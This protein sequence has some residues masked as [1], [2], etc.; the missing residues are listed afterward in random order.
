MKRSK[1]FNKN[2]PA[3]YMLQSTDLRKPNMYATTCKPRLLFFQF[4]YDP[5]LPAFLS[6]HA[7]EHAKCLAHFFE[8]TV[9]DED[10]DYQEICELYAPDIAVFESGV[11]FASCR[12]PRITNTKSCPQVPKIGFLN[13]DAFGEG[14]SGFL[15]DM[16]HWGIETFFAIATTAAEHIPELAPNLFIWPNFVDADLYRDYGESK[17]IPVLFTGNKNALYPWRQ[18]IARIVPRHYP[19]LVCP[20]PGY[21]PLQGARQPITGEPYARML[22]AAW[23]IPACGTVAREVVRKHFEVPACRSCLVTQR[24]FALE[25]AGFV[26]MENCVFA[27]AGNVLGKMAFLFEHPDKL[28]AVIDGGHRLVRSRHTSLERDQVLQWFILHKTLPPD[29]RIAQPNPFARLEIVRE[30]SKAVSPSENVAPDSLVALVRHGDEQLRKG[31]YDAAETFYFKCLN[32]YRFMPEPQLRLAICSLYKGNA[33]AALSWITKPIQFT[34]AEYKATDPDPVEWAYFIVT[35]LCLGRIDDAT[36]RARQFGWLHHPQLERVRNIVEWIVCGTSGKTSSPRNP[37]LSVHCLPVQDLKEWIRQLGLMLSACGRPK[38]VQK[39]T[40]YPIVNG[41]GPIQK[42]PALPTILTDAT[43]AS[44]RDRDASAEF[45]RQLF[46]QRIKASLKGGVK[47]LVDKVK[48]KYPTVTSSVLTQSRNDPYFRAIQERVMGETCRSVLI[49]GAAPRESSTRAMLAA[50]RRT[51]RPNMFGIAISKHRAGSRGETAFTLWH[52]L[53]STSSN[54]VSEEIDQVITRIRNAHQIQQFDLVIIDGSEL[55]LELANADALQR[56]LEA[57]HCVVLDDINHQF[58]HGRYA[59]L[60]DDSRF[61]LVDQDLSRRQGYA[62]FEHC[63]SAEAVGY[64]PASP[65]TDG[66]G[67]RKVAVVS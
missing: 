60:L 56:C 2:P 64:E 12:K 9:V 20:H 7:R 3:F 24:S 11:P 1:L 26:D 49:V 54:L 34:L 6:M 29:A 33:Q 44:G 17:N 50:L 55:S 63:S 23:F 37:R 66:F 14:R 67:T 62:I 10:C 5:D 35:L 21:S 22:N 61:A 18:E 8:V 42:I 25:A 51:V 13:A 19:S 43:P 48:T 52:N 30:T 53:R 58:N 32:H 39:L 16:D 4:R 36:K 45:R 15:S 59:R 28:Q 40:S 38:L 65:W 27:E 47:K 41:T 57:A 31:M 46:Y